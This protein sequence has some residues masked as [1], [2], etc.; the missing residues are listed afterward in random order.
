MN[1][2]DQ[3]RLSPASLR[4]AE[5]TTDTASAIQIA[6]WIEALIDARARDLFETALRQAWGASVARAERP[7][8]A[9]EARRKAP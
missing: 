9:R 3:N 2:P 4:K 7:E 6:R 1:A 5:P 8:E